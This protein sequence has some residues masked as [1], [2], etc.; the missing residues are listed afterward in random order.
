VD[1]SSESSSKT[2]AD[3]ELVERINA[4]DA[5]AFETLYLRYRDWTARLAFRY[6][7]DRDEALDVVQETFSYVL[8]KFPGFELRARFTTFLFPTVKHLALSRRE[9][10]S[11]MRLTGDAAEAG[12]AEAASGRG[13][14][15]AGEG[16]PQAERD[17][18]DDAGSL[19]RSLN[20]DQ[21]E[22]VLLRFVDDLSIEEIALATGAAEGTVKSRLHH[23]VRKLRADPVVRDYFAPADASSSKKPAEPAAE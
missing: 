12:E 17:F 14:A 23:A 3:A 20:A 11:R 4:G 13:R 15:G 8:R 2:P 9:R 19:L 6:T 7:H 18:R 16:D 22:A 10:R 5:A 1:A 21:R